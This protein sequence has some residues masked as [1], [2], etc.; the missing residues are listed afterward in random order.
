MNVNYEVVIVGGGPAGLS[1][2][3]NLGRARRRVLLLDAGPRR[4]AAAEHVHGFVT[5]DG[6]TPNEFRRVARA[7]LEPYRSVEVRDA[8]AE[9]IAGERGA[10]ELRVAGEAVHARRV[11]LCTGMVDQLPGIEGFAERWGHSIFACPYCHG[12]EIQ[13][14]A[15]GVLATAPEMLELAILL[16]AWTSDVVALTH[17]RLD[18]SPEV[19]ARLANAGVRLDERPIARLVGPEARL[20]RI[21]L[22]HGEPLRVDALFARPPQR[23]VSVVAQLDLALDPAGY[24]VLDD[25]LQTSRPGIYAA[26]DLVTPVQSAVLAAAAG[27]RTAAMLNHELTAELATTGALS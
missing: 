18:V 22:E 3:L 14:R 15:F 24:L 6:V 16:R 20:E 26:G 8:A 13:D 10:F 19:K 17:G 2:A 21:E 7:Q 27:M 23:Q 12:W 11:L 1:A 9:R 5:R 25:H 4:N